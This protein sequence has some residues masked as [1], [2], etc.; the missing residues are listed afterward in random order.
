V[1]PDAWGAVLFD[2][3]GTLVDSEPASR[4]AFQTYFTSRG[5]DVAPEVIREFA[6]RR[7]DDVFAQLP[8]PWTGEPPESLLR[9]VIGHFDHEANPPAVV[10]GAAELVRDLHD[11][12]VPIALVT[13]SRRWWA[14]RMLGD[15][16]GVLDCFTALIT[17]E[18][19]SAGKPDPAPYRTG[20]AALNVDPVT[21]VVLEDTVAGIQAALGAGVGHVI[22]V[23]T[24]SAPDV[25]LDAGAH[26]V[27]ADLT[28]LT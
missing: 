13:S 12:R 18:D 8:G 15:L 4:A 10:P 16:L 19:T 1:R 27:V 7:G 20:V 2:L 11:R 9:D 21:A 28:E 14:E 6:G 22:G 23:S 25:L 5:W 17:A 26:R 3:D 24:S